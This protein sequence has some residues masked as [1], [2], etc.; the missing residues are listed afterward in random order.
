MQI[1]GHAQVSVLDGGLERWL[2][3]NYTVSD[4][5]A[6]IDL[7]NWTAS[8][9]PSLVI[10]YDELAYPESD[11]YCLLHR[12]YWVIELLRKFCDAVIVIDLK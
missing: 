7:G 3:G 2:A 1:Y 9:L 10:S 6:Q 11:G 12:L 5:D 4:V 8:F